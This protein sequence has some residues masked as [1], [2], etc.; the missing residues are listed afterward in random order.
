MDR[1]NHLMLP[2]STVLL[3]QQKLRLYCGGKS[4]STLASLSSLF[5]WR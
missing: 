5:L 3:G 1:K 2:I 4:P